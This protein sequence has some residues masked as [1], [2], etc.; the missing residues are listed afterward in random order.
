MNKRDRIVQLIREMMVANLPG[1]GGGFSS[2][3][4]SGMEN[5]V[6]GFDPVLGMFKRTKKGKFD[7][8]VKKRYKNWLP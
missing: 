1:T 8:R 4:P 7:R 2:N 6:A 3:P 5:T